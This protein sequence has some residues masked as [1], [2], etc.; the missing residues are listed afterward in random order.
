MMS[1]N[2]MNKIIKDY[3]KSFLNHGDSPKSVMW[4]KGRQEERFKAL[5]RFVA[6]ENHFSI[7]DYGCGLAHLV[8]YLEK[9]FKKYDYT[10]CDIVDDFIKH[11]SSK[12]KQCTF[13]NSINQKIKLNYDCTVVSG[14]FNLLYSEDEVE[15]KKIVYDTIKMLFRHTNKILSINFMTDQVDFQSSNAYHQNVKDLYDF[16][17]ENITRR[18]N[19]DQTYMPY[20][21]TIT[22]FCNQEI[23]IPINTYTI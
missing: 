12:F 16:C 11:N 14:A 2:M 9:N 7:L 10:G 13:F 18:L 1:S 21:F 8:E 20:E 15:H 19:I 17:F 22:L 4:P 6:K 5:L 3:S 23:Q